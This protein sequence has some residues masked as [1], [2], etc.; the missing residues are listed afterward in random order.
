MAHFLLRM[1][2]P[3]PSFPFDMSEEEKALFERHFAY[4]TERAE[5]GEAIAAGPVFDPEGPW[6]LAL[7]EAADEAEAA[8]IGA[9]DPVITA[10]AGFAYSLA[11]IPT[12]ILRPR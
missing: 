9:A 1:T 11:P 2:A 10:Q 7:V 5:A 12:L 6:G 3:R 4:W 8:R